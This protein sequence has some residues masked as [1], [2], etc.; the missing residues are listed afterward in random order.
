VLDGYAYTLADTEFYAPPDETSEVGRRFAPS[1]VPAGWTAE[2]QAI[3]TSWSAPRIATPEHG[4]K[5]HVSA[6]LDRADW[7]LDQV[8]EACFEERVR[9]KHVSA[10]L[11]FLLLHHKHGARAQAGKFCAAFPAGE[12]AARRLMERLSGALAAEDGPYVLSDRRYG[13][14]RTV[15]YRWGA[16]RP[17]A[18]LRPD[19]SREWLV[20]DGRG[21]EVED[22]RGP[23]FV[24]PDG[25]ADPFAVA[26]LPGHRGPVVLRGY[27]IVRALRISNAGGAYEA[28]HVH[29]GRRVFIKEARAHNGLYWDGSSAQC[30]LRREHEVLCDLHARSSRVAPEPHGNHRRDAA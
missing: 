8:A 2:Q 20:R 28:R 22:A 1:C 26:P 30:R 14:S 11:F 13:C 9:F 3:W 23:S 6:R 4:W 5:V 29:S 19:G 12:A 15:H 21:G 17:R 10:E 24:L 7:V 16:F 18:R 25:I 27:E